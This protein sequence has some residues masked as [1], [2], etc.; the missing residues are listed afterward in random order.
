MICSRLQHQG[1]F[2]YGT[3]TSLVRSILLPSMDTILSLQLLSTLPNMLKLSFSPSPLVSKCPSLSCT[4]FF[5]VMEFPPLSSLIMGPHLKT[6][7]YVISF[8][9]YTSNIIGPPHITPKRMATMRQPI[10]H[11]SVSS[12][13]LPMKLVMTNTSI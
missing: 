1:L 10:I 13:G 8:L 4:T 11:C 6:N 5:F 9:H 3:R 12:R 2:L 7:T